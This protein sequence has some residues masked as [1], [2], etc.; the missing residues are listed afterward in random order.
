MRWRFVRNS[1][2]ILPIGD[3]ADPDDVA[4]HAIPVNGLTVSTSRAELNVAGVLQ[5]KSP[6]GVHAT[7]A[8]T[9]DD[10]VWDDPW[11]DF[12]RGD[13]TNLPKRF[14]WAVFKARNKL[15][16]NME[17]VIYDGY[18][19]D[20][21]GD[22]RQRLYVVEAIDGPSQN[23]VTLRGVDPLMLADSRTSLFPPA[24]G[25]SLLAA[26]TASQTTID[27]VTNDVANL[28]TVVGLTSGYYIII[29]SEIIRYSGFTV[30]SPGLYRLGG[31]QRGQGGSTPAAASA[32]E[33][34]GR[35]GHFENQLLPDVAEYLLSTWTPV[36][37]ARIDAAGWHDERDGFLSVGACNTFVTTPT[38]VVD[39]MGELCQQGCFN[40]WWDEYAQKVKLIS[41][42]PPHGSVPLLTDVETILADSADATMD[43][44]AR[45]TRVLVFYDPIDATKSDAANYRV[46]SVEVEGD[47][48]RIEAGGVAKTLIIYGRWVPSEAQAYQII[49][50]ILL[51]YRA[52]PEMMTIRVSAKDR[53]IAVGQTVDVQSRTTPD[54]EG[55]PLIRRWQVTSWAEVVAGQVYELRLQDYSLNGRFAFVA[56]DN[57]LTYE[58][59][60]EAERVDTCFLAGSDGL[61]P[62]GSPGYLLQ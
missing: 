11:G 24:Y 46:V 23:K 10:F 45:L 15:F 27:V 7:C 48:E 20:A 6:F 52:I 16:S 22:M 9:M 53:D 1:P 50:R 25:I 51:R 32:G 34:V 8:V 58:D 19:G 2:G 26:I 49:S 13:R 54:S 37:A 38:P 61:M 36:G 56:A 44:D 39:L 3:F 35:V 55:R 62:D 5:G 33:K 31:I 43:P 30:L 59:A 60:T 29:G 14:F 42:R 4:T 57:G 47:G 17:L 40:V 28:S 41:V 18:V 21:L 12:Y